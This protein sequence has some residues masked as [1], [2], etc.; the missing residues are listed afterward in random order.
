M[1]RILF[2]LLFSVATFSISAEISVKSFRKLDNDMTARIDAPKRDQNGDVCAI[3]KVVTSQSGFTFDC[4]QIGVIATDQHPSEIWVYVPYGTK[5]ITIS[6]PVLGV[7]RDY[8]IPHSIEKACVYEMVL[9][10]GKVI[11]TVEESIESQWLLITPEP[12]DAMIYLNDKFVGNGVYQAKHKA[13]KYTYRVE[14]PLYH[15]DAGTINIVDAKKELNVKLQPAFGYITVNSS[16]EE[17]AKVLIDGKPQEKQ[18]PFQS[19]AIASGE[20]TVQVVKDM[21]QPALQKVTVMDGQ[22]TPV[23]LSLQPNFAVVSITT[24]IDASISVNGMQKSKGN[25]TGRLNPGVYSIESNKEKYLSAKQDIE[26]VAGDKKI[27]DLQPTPIC[28]SLDVVTTPP[29]ANVFLNG[30]IIGTTPNSIHQLLIGEYQLKIEKQGFAAI[31]KKVRIEQNKTNEIN[32]IL[33][34]SK[35]VIITSTP[36]NLEL[37]VDGVVVGKTPKTI[38]LSYDFH[39]IEVSEGKEKTNQTIEI[40][41]KTSNIQIDLYECYSYKT[42]TSS[43]SYAQIY[44][45]GNYF[46]TTPYTFIMKSKKHNIKLKKEGYKTINKT[47]NCDDNTN[48]NINLSKTFRLSDTELY[49]KSY[50]G[51]SSSIGYSNIFNDGSDLFTDAWNFDFGLYYSY[52]IN[53]NIFLKNDVCINSIE[54]KIENYNSGSKKYHLLFLQDNISLCAGISIEGTYGLIH[55]YNQLIF[56]EL[57]TSL[58]K[59]IQSNIIGQDFFSPIIGIGF[60]N[61]NG[62]YTF[63]L[64]PNYRMLIDNE[65]AYFTFNINFS[66]NPNK[67]FKVL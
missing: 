2:L 48:I 52:K 26:V 33:K 28:G 24:A 37:V 11:T 62:S 18:T 13:G 23:S 54:T 58:N 45:D 56:L 27:I 38:D 55:D 8:I 31:D 50:I 35:S 43:P 34:S 12:A 3:I 9:T 51:F 40:T 19:A 66:F 61:Y 29:N 21:F 57:G 22:T 36:S 20:H 1:K 49:D 65:G 42:I 60:G 4:G 25:W 64:Y 63:R 59:K 67:W 10:T 16:P 53:D 46:G 5:R 6:H 30:A 15:T 39:N 41:D 32:E 17:N 47:I 14:A 7:L 44:I